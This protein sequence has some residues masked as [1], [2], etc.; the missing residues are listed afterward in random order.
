MPR[1]SRHLLGK[2]LYSLLVIRWP[3]LVPE[4]N[5]LPSFF[6]IQCLL[7]RDLDDTNYTGF[8]YSLPSFLIIEITIISKCTCFSSSFS[9]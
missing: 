8:L 3:G 7:C 6:T 9:K 2:K 4:Y 1:I 5:V